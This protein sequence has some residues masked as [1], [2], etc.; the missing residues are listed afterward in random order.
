ME[1]K[2]SLTGVVFA[3]SGVLVSSTYTIWVSSVAKK[4]NLSS[5]QLLHNQAPVS[6]LILLVLA[7]FLDSP[8]WPPLEALPWV[9]ASGALAILIN[10][11]Q[12]KIIHGTC[13]LTST[14]VGNIKTITIVSLGWALG[15]STSYDSILGVTMA[16][17][18]ALVYT[19]DQQKWTSRSHKLLSEVLLSFI[20]LEPLCRDL[21][22]HLSF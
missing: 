20:L 22:T 1:Q 10:V 14:I 11:S 13:P 5:M 17:S 21:S 9:L 18:G 3:L 12:F 6:I 7:P 4:F 8:T 16:L 19:A 15:G 2:T